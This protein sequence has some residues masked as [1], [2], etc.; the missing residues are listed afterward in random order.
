MI[1][2]LILDRK[3]NDSLIAQGYTHAQLFT[4]ELKP[5]SYDPAKFYR[6]CMEYSTIFSGIGDDITAAMD[7]G[8]ESDVVSALCAYIM[9]NK[10]NPGICDYIRSVKW[11]PEERAA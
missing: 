2:D 7:G 5:L 8:E 10:Y 3:E 1:I 6:D 4:G 9:Q 11:L